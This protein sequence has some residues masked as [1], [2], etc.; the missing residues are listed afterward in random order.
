VKA[1]ESF[2]TVVTL[3]RGDARTDR[4]GCLEIYDGKRWVKTRWKAEWMLKQEENSRTP[5]AALESPGPY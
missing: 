5:L 3:R 1:Y 4:E 2:P